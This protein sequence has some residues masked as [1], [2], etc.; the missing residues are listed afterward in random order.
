MGRYLMDTFSDSDNMQKSTILSG[1]VRIR[2]NKAAIDDIIQSVRR[3]IDEGKEL[4]EAE[5][6]VKREMAE[7]YGKAWIE[8]SGEAIN[9]I[10]E[11][12]YSLSLYNQRGGK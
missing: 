11:N 7:K 9:F 10:V 5:E 1:L 6:L 8:D 3:S 12:E 2:G 4:Y